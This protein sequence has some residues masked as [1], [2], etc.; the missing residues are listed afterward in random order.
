MNALVNLARMEVPVLM[1][2]TDSNVNVRLDGEELLAKK[3]SLFVFN[4]IAWMKTYTWYLGYIECFCK[5]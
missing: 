3:V 2:S 4:F 1:V 5:Q